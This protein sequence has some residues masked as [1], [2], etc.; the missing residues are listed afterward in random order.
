MF[1]DGKGVK[2]CNV[3]NKG[4]LWELL[5]YLL[6]IV[7]FLWGVFVCFCFE[8]FVELKVFDVIFFL[9]LEIF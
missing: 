4:S 5:L 2:C 9:G 8:G 7:L 6:G 1:G 3:M